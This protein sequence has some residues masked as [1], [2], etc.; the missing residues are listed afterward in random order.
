MATS[1]NFNKPPAFGD[2]KPYSRY[3][4]ELR[5]W[6]Y[7]TNVAKKK[8]GVAVALSLPEDD[9]SQIRD[10][11]F[12]EINMDDLKKDDGVETLIAFFDTV[13]K[14][15]E[16]AEVYEHYVNFDRYK[17]IEI[18]TMDSY[19][20]EFEKRYNKTKKFKMQ[21]PESV[22]AFKLL[23]NSGLQNNDRLLVLTGVDYNEQDSL[24]K[25]MK[26]SLKKFFG[27]QAKPIPPEQNQSIKIESP[28]SSQEQEANVVYRQHNRNRGG[29]RGRGRGRYNSNRGRPFI[30]GNQ[31]AT[32]RKSNPSDGEGNVMRCMV[33]DSKLH[34]VKDC[35]HA[36][37][38]MEQS[39]FIETEQFALFTGKNNSE[40]NVLLTESTNSAVLDSGCSST[41]A[42]KDWIDCF[43]GSLNEV[44]KAEVIYK[45][46]DTV[47]KFGGGERLQSTGKVILPCYLAGQKCTI[48]TDII[49]SDIP[50]LLSKSAMKKAGMKLDLVN[51]KAEVYGKTVNLQS[52]SA[53]HYCIPLRDTSIDIECCFTGVESDEEISKVITKLHK[54]FAHPSPKR[55]KGLLRDA[56]VLSPA[57]SKVIDDIATNCQICLKFKKTPARPVVSLPLATS[58][59]EVVVMDLKKW[60]QNKWILHLID[61][62]TG[63]TMSRIINDKK[64]STIVDNVM[65]MW[66]GSGF[67]CAGKFLADNGG[68]FANEEYKDMCANLN[69]EVR[70]TAA[71]SPWQNG[72]CERNHAVVDECLQKILEE[73]PKMKVETALVWAIH[74]KN[75]L[76]MNSGY[77]SYQLLFGQNP[78]LPSV[79]I[80]KPPALEGTTISKQFYKHLNGLHSG[81]RAFIQ[82]ESSER[83][84]RALRHQLRSHSE[85]FVTGDPVFYKR[86]SSNKWM[87]PG[88]VIGQDGN[89]I[90]VRHGSVYVRVPNCRILKVGEEFNNKTSD[91]TCDKINDTSSK[92]SSSVDSEAITDESDTSDINREPNDQSPPENCDDE[93]VPPTSVET[94]TTH[95]DSNPK[96]KH[97]PKLQ[98]VVRIK[99]KNSEQWKSARIIS[100][101]GKA[102]GK[103][104]SW[105]NVE[106]LHN[107]ERLCLDFS[108][109]EWEDQK[110]DSESVNYNAIFH[111]TNDR[112]KELVKEAKEKELLNWKTFDVYDQVEFKNQP[113]ISTRWVVT[114][115]QPEPNLVVKARLVV[116]GFEET[117]NIPSDSPTISKDSLRTCL[118]IASSKQWPLEMIDIK[119]AFLQG[120]DI[121]REIFVKPPTEAKVAENLVWKLRKV[122][123]GLNDASRNWYF[124][125]RETLLKLGCVQSTID[126][127]LFMWRDSSNQLAGMFILHVDDFLY[128]GSQTFSKTVVK[129][130]CEIY[131]VGSKGTDIFK[132]I[133]LEVSTN[134]NETT[135][136]QSM[137]VKS[138]KEIPIR[139]SRKLRKNDKVTSEEEKLLRTAIGQLNWVATQTRPDLSYDVLELSM[140]TNR[141][142]VDHL[143]QA[144]KVIRKLKSE[145]LQIKFPRLGELSNLKLMLFNDASFANLPD[146]TSSTG[147]RVVFLSGEG[148]KCC[149]ISWSSTKIKRVVRS[150]LA[151][152]TLSLADGSE[153]VFVIGCLL[154]ELIYG[155]SDQQNRIP[156]K[157]FVDN[158]SLVQNVHSTTM[159][160]E[161]RLR[162]E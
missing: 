24:Y 84:R 141:A 108:S 136:S 16:L 8:Q 87:G 107:N 131:K 63:F 111:A 140:I 105:F 7:V 137:Y 60:G 144:N 74:A 13:F 68:E 26:S 49:E 52:T 148:D 97:L 99:D 19:I 41:V 120:E 62:A 91:Q 145:A 25:Q 17:K 96:G 31:P 67:G 112:E 59:N 135:L 54:Q 80:D 50:M 119:S 147:G 57:C 117:S 132:Y 124:T 129:K 82:A 6:T 142:T 46:S 86:E 76:Q 55:L 37:E 160:S 156:I 53:G 1:E 14:K 35:P 27:Q 128:A 22:L 106:T 79:I 78:N 121:S 133:G 11:V 123:Y 48:E 69:I 109:I 28:E 21:L 51:D 103:F 23:E 146:G 98:D 88:K 89:T 162:I 143:L 158:K 150:T 118:A 95:A 44:E 45:D 75:C 43:V 159:V 100:R 65:L 56:G 3:V 58:F 66:I 64:P 33:C 134:Q 15:D 110:V 122:V 152:E 12:N 93:L 138:I 4:E 38:N 20:L 115:K 9:K 39:F 2:D 10:K 127:A 113:L 102:S 154:T 47:Y 30:R 157:S 139:P 61:A 94:T 34:F 29:G 126:K 161:K 36:Y 92:K 155:K 40:M 125:I 72:L 114:E 5:A 70:N 73:N 104:A 18:D 116:R 101:G 153:G 90:F 81:R 130:V 71:Q 42:G 83:I 151:A 77:S 149:P 32:G 85:M